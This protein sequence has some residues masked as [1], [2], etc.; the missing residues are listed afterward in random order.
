MKIGVVYPQTE[1]KGDPEAVRAIGLA[2]EALGY[3]HLLTYD[4]VLGAT[5]DREPKLTG[6][7]TDRH[8][9]HDPFVMFSYLAGITKRIELTTGI[10]ILPQRQTALVAK[11]AADLDLMSHGRLRLGVGLGWNYVEYHALGQD[12]GTRGARADEQIELLRQLW[13]KPLLSFDGRFDH[14]DRAGI[15]PRPKRSIPIWVGGMTEAAFRRS[16]KLGDGHLFMGEVETAAQA[17]SRVEHY[18]REAGRAA[19]AFG[20]ELIVGGTKSPTEIAE[21]IANWRNAGGTHASVVTMGRGLETTQAHID[22]LA[23]VRDQLRLTLALRP[24]SNGA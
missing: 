20:R 19:E 1:L 11:Q 15:L 3:D 21:V 2:V 9:F 16:G 6:P 23:E 18:L 7:Y 4:H 5:H 10:L 24:P 14:I 8:P 17:W 12:F 13:S 22:F